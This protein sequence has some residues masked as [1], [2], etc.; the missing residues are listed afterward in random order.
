MRT[1]V[2]SDFKGTHCVRRPISVSYR[3]L[4]LI[5]RIGVRALQTQRDLL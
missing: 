4:L 3:A 1:T 2:E 5:S